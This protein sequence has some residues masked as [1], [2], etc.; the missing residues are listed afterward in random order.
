MSFETTYSQLHYIPLH[1]T[2]V[3]TCDRLYTVF[4]QLHK[5]LT[6]NEVKGANL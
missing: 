1:A 5:C 3:V 4:N 2:A 6:L